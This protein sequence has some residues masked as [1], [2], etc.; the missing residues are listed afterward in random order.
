MGLEN[1]AIER[2][3]RGAFFT[4]QPIADFL[5]EWAINSR[6]DK[7]FEPSCG[8][9]AFLLSAHRLRARL[10]ISATDGGLFG[11]E[12][13][14][15]TARTALEKLHAAGAKCKILEQDFFQFSS[16]E[17]FDVI[18]GN[19]PF[20]RYQTFSGDDRTQGLEAALR[21]GVRLN[22]LS[23]AWAAFLVHSCSFLNST[24]RMGFVLPAELLSVNYAGTVRNYLM[25]RFA[26]LKIVTFEEMVFP[27]VQEE[28]ILLLASGRGHTDRF[29]LFQAKNL[30][31]LSG[32]LGKR[33]SYFK[34][35]TEAEKW[36]NAFVPEDVLALY[37]NCTAQGRFETLNKWGKAYLGA[38]TGANEFFLLSRDDVANS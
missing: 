19:P 22:K 16:E 37:R 34:P 6:T 25:N 28:I 38:V 12:I 35:T 11:V 17:K 30:N 8:E 4:P 14:T 36:T 7:I 29:E 10:P 20:I 27:A 26:S 1:Q 13:H 15:D 31:D 9:A 21:Q 32:A 33:W 3:H 5:A 23:S 24:G 2:K 18:L